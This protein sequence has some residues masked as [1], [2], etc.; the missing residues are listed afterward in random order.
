MTP[1]F[2]T[3]TPALPH[4]NLTT[5]PDWVRAAIAHLP[6]APGDWQ[7]RGIV[8]CGGGIRYFLCAWVCINMLR[9]QGC[10]LPVELWHLNSAEM[11]DAMRALVEPLGVRCINAQQVHSLFPRVPGGW[12]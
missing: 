11:N 4:L 1:A 10:V 6:E 12:E 2:S 8:I 3:P 9:K 5:A 7:G